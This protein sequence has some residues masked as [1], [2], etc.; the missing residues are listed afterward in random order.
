[1]NNERSESKR[2][3]YRRRLI[4]YLLVFFVVHL[5]LVCAASALAIA[6]SP[7]IPILTTIALAIVLLDASFGITEALLTNRANE[8]LVQLRDYATSGIPGESKVAILVPVLLHSAAQIDS[9]VAMARWNLRISN[10]SSVLLVFV[11][12]FKDATTESLDLDERLLKHE[13]ETRVQAEAAE[14]TPLYGNCLHVI[15]RYP[16]FSAIDRLWRGRE[17]KRGKIELLNQLIEGKE[18]KDT[19]EASVDLRE[20]LKAVKYV[21]VLDEDSKL[22]PNTLQYLVGFMDHPSNAPVFE[23]GELV[24]G[25][26]LVV[27]QAVI[28]RSSTL[29]WRMARAICGPCADP[30]FEAKPASDFSYRWFG[31]SRYTGKGLYEVKAYDRACELKIPENLILSH[32]TIEG[33]FLR[34]GFSP[35]GAI[36]DGFPSSHKAIFSR[37]LRWMRGDVQNIYFA[38]ST[39]LSSKSHSDRGSI[40]GTGHLALAQQL[41]ALLHSLLGFP[42]VLLII[43]R[44]GDWLQLIMLALV[45]GGGQ[46]TRLVG[47]IRRDF[48]R[49]A[50]LRF[51]FSVY[52]AYLLR[53]H[54]ALIHKL[55]LSPIAFLTAFAA[56]CQSSRSLLSGKDRL[57]WNSAHQTDNGVAR[58]G[59]VLL[60]GSTAVAWTSLLWLSEITIASAAGIFFALLWAP[61]PL[62]DH[63]LSRG[64]RKNADDAR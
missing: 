33:A 52:P 3:T 57:R 2:H 61:L 21:L 54:F 9:L 64:R 22:T 48:E 34:A 11:Y 45:Y 31:A 10:D 20:I 19:I 38:I 56:L 60:L 42:L 27:C 17:R 13:F 8:G 62:C 53:L 55:F 41:S 30:R 14:L 6:I 59:H 4:S 29:N 51:W 36:T 26:A 49:R 39:I 7:K 23:E 32:D 40:P 16:T 43:I 44:G 15:Y 47:N 18:P 5:V 37:S 63:I 58:D 28:E 1:M 12:D 50:P 25:H 35:F 24:L 46:Y